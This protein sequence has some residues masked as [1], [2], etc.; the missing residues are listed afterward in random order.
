MAE[1]CIFCKIVAGEIPA[2]KVYEDERAVAFQDIHPS[3]P[4]HL[5]IVP[6]EHIV[7]VN[8]ATSANEG[9]LGHLFTVAADLAKKLGVDQ[10][11]YRVAVSTGPDAGQLVWHFHM[12]FLAGRKLGWP[13]G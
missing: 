6:R 13:P 8:E 1:D 5:L 10:S 4:H 2:E 11:G 9:T 3:A 7:S 12:H